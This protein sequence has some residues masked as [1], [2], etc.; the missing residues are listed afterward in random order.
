MAFTQQEY[1]SL[2]SA[3]ALGALT[4]KYADKEVTYRS[5]ADMK[6]ILNEMAN[7]LGTSSAPVRRKYVDASNGVYSDLK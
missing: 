6:A 7:E 4:V 3:Y 1:D 5:R 2:K